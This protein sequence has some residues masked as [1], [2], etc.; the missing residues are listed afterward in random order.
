M[1][2]LRHQ[3]TRRVFSLDPDTLIGR[4]RRCQLL[5]EHESASHVHASIRWLGGMWHVQD[6]NSTNGTWLDGVCLSGGESQ[7]LHVG[8]TLR[9]GAKHSEEWLFIDS[10]APPPMIKQLPDGA[11]LFLLENKPIILSTK[12]NAMV[13]WSPGGAVLLERGHAPEFLHDGQEF[14]VDGVHYTAFLPVGPSTA[15]F[16]RVLSQTELVVRSEAGLELTVHGKT[17]RLN[18]RAPYVV[19]QALAEERLK[20]R[21]SGSSEADEGW[22]D[23]QT[24]SLQLRRAD[25]NQDIRRIRKQFHELELF[26]SADDIIETL[27]DQSKIR[28]GIYRVKVR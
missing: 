3:Q 17:H 21:E 6:R 25:L 19:L 18:W 7:R 2:R 4:S 20:D 5:V 16:E 23:R 11:P 10:T 15:T 14:A 9:F 8:S 24:L 12:T 1:G 28:L 26:E 13:C 27:R 22:L